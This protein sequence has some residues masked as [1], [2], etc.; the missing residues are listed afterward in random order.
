MRIVRS[1]FPAVSIFA[2]NR[3]EG[4]VGPVAASEPED[5]LLT[6]P[7]L[8][9]T[10]RRLPP[11]GAVFLAHLSAGDPLGAAAAAAFA[12]SP[13]FDLPANLAGVLAAGVF[14]AADPGG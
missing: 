2:A 6:R 10:V 7:R 13:E 9:V 14:I 4:P 8:E 5:A 1:R 3:S 12:D 11:G